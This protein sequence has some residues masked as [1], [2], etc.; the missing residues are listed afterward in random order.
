MNKYF[1]IFAISLQQEF[2]YKITFIMWRV[3]NVLQIFLVFFLW[4]SV[5]SDPNKIVF[6]YSRAKILTY[7]FGLLI[8][9]SIVT[10]G[11]SNDIAGEIADGRLTNYLLKPINYFKYWFT[12]DIS[13]KALNLTF[14]VIETIGLLLILNPPF[15]IQTNIGYLFPFLLFV[16]LSLVLFFLLSL[17]FE[18]SPFWYPENAWGLMFILGILVD[19][20]AGGVFPL[21]IL[22]QNVQS[23]LY[24]TPFPYLLF[25]PIQIYLGKL[26]PD[27]LLRSMVIISVWVLGLSYLVN[28]IW[29]MGLKVYRAEG[30]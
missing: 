10:G 11:R 20:L 2:V 4:D 21:D 8:L 28:R 24:L 1:Q 17:I 26:S 3:R 18:M 15:F 30:R 29:N 6:G 14:A 23:I 16:V 27:L 9:K 7:I 25:I 22:P 19:F 12:R 13:V 5:F